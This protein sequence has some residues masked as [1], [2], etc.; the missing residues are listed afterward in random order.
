MTL[1]LI[2]I[3]NLLRRKGKA[4]F[5]TAGLVIGVTTVVAIISL[6]EAMTLDI[7][8]KLEKFG[9]NILVVPR[10]ENLSLTYGG[11]SIGGVSFDIE[12]ILE[13]EL[14]D[15]MIFRTT[16]LRNRII[17]E[18]MARGGMRVGEV[19]KITPGDIEDRKVIIWEPKSGKEAEIV[20]IPQKVADR[21]KD[22]IRKKDIAHD[23]RIFPITYPAARMMAL[24]QWRNRPRRG[25]ISP[26]K[27][28]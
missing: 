2:A 20:F 8:D 3:R 28:S 16:N 23:R 9:A 24:R 17:L 12:K 13:K 15:E 5:I 10:T 11:L 21:L 22:Y 27:I 1:R 4:A 6:I 14:V 18:L 25:S 7:N 19:L 26:V